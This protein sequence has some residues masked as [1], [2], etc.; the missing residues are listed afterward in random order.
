MFSLL[1]GYFGYNEVLVSD[2][3]R[4]KRVSFG[5]VNVGVIFQC[6]MDI[7]FYGLIGKSMVFYLDD[8]IVFS[9]RRSDHKC[10]LKKFFE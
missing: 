10:H 6:I 7:T 1:D 9:K 4:L 2:P 5:L 8:V 3:D